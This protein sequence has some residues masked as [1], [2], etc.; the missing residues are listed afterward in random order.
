M[1]VSG[2]DA[3]FSGRRRS[4]YVNTCRRVAQAST[5]RLSNIFAAIRRNE[6]A[7]SR[8]KLTQGRDAWPDGLRELGEGR[9]LDVSAMGAQSC[10]PLRSTFA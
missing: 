1:E 5:I 10:K 2:E 4:A 6:L 3:N 9:S 7:R 8:I